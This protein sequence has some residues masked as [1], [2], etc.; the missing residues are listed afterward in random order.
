[1]NKGICSCEK[2]RKRLEREREREREREKENNNL[3]RERGR[4]RKIIWRERSK[5]ARGW[6]DGEKNEKEREIERAKPY[7]QH[8]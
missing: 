2:R 5:S 4:R 3:K 7:L 6:R 1:M 8:N